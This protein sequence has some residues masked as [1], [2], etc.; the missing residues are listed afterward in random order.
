MLKL[1][2]IPIPSAGEWRDARVLTRQARSVRRRRPSPS[3]LLLQPGIAPFLPPNA[4]PRR[5]YNSRTADA[6]FL[7]SQ[8]T[9]TGVTPPMI[10]FPALAAS[11]TL[12]ASLAAPALAQ[13]PLRATLTPGQ[14]IRCSVVI[15]QHYTNTYVPPS[16]EPSERFTLQTVTAVLKARDDKT[17]DLSYETYRFKFTPSTGDVIDLDVAGPVPPATDTTKTNLYTPLKT[18]TATK[19]VLTLKPDGSIDTVTGGEELLKNGSIR[20][21]RRLVEADGIKT[22]FSSVLAL[23]T[24]KPDAAVGDKWSIQWVTL[25][26]RGRELLTEDRTLD[27]VADNTA[28]IKGIVRHTGKPANVGVGAIYLRDALANSTFSWDTAA[29]ALKAA[30]VEDNITLVMMNPDQSK[31]EMTTFTTTTLNVLPSKAAPAPAAPAA[32]PAPAAPAKH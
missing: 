17:L 24:D 23:R 16:R 8:R 14:E 21:M 31:N 2:D 11:V 18:I 7:R 29:R 32:T 28:I 12:S 30:K 22:I 15:D 3:T 25:A 6:L 26:D 4:Y 27:K 10:Q 9:H 1:R 19:F 13:V 20:L 5:A